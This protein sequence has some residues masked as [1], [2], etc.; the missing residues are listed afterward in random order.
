M[1]FT[2]LKIDLERVVLLA[3]PLCWFNI[4]DVVLI[5]CFS[6]PYN[7]ETLNEKKL[8]RAISWIVNC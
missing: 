8:A 6:F 5:V 4:L 1:L 3:F 2:L 7:Y